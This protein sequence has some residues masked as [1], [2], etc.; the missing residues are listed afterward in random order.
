MQWIWWPRSSGDCGPKQE[1]QFTI[2]RVLSSTA[3]QQY[4][5]TTE[6][7]IQQPFTTHTLTCGRP[8]C[9]HVEV[10]AG[11]EKRVVDVRQ[12]PP[13]RDVARDLWGLID[14]AAL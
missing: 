13:P 1:I 6:T 3:V 11:R 5:S 9:A 4:S 7:A 12:P 2:Y 8:L 10:N 14:P